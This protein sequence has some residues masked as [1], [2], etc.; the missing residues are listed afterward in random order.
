MYD[1]HVGRE[2]V[3]NRYSRAL[4]FQMVGKI[5]LLGFRLDCHVL[6]LARHDS[7]SSHASIGSRQK[8]GEKRQA[9]G[10]KSE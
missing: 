10:C 7:F 6:R 9:E 5:R 8:G 2:F 3:A 1:T 4:I